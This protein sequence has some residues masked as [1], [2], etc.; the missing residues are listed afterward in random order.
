MEP[1]TIV[2][3]RTGVKSEWVAAFFYNWDIN[4]WSQVFQLHLGVDTNEFSS[5]VLNLATH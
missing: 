2:I 4:L 1:K 5:V 3:S